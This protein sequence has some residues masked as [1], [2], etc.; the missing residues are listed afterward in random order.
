MPCFV[1][2]NGSFVLHAKQLL[3]KFAPPGNIPMPLFPV[4]MYHGMATFS[5]NLPSLASLPTRSG[6]IYFWQ[7]ELYT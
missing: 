2:S 5:L 6:L 4:L 1:G 3:R 7:A